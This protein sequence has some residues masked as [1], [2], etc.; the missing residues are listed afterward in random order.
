MTNLLDVDDSTA[1]V[2]NSRLQV[3]L[4][5]TPGFAHHLISSC[6]I[7]FN[8]FNGGFFFRQDNTIGDPNNFIELMRIDPTINPGQTVL[9]VR[10]NVGGAF[11]TQQVK[12]GPANSGGAPGFRLLRVEMP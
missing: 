2:T 6:D 8:S 7:C 12:V 3:G 5:G 9:F 4:R 10:V 1:A 11:S